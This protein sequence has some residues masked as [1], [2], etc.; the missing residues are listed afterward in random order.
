MDHAIGELGA[1]LHESSRT[2]G[3]SWTAP[4]P[5]AEDDEHVPQSVFV[6]SGYRG[7]EDF[8]R[9]IAEGKERDAQR[10]RRL[11]MP[12]AN[13]DVCSALCSRWQ[14]LRA[15]PS[16]VSDVCEAPSRSTCYLCSCPLSF[17]HANHGYFWRSRL[18]LQEVGGFDYET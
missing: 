5:L 3:E 16:C 17:L 2:C 1:S 7:S 15:H 18:M 8:G 12:H 11:D 14:R 9:L 13:V 4:A 10:R 6:F